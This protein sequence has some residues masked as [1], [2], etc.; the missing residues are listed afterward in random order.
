MNAVLD[1]LARLGVVPVLVL[2]DAS[3][4]DALAAALIEGGL[5]TAEVTLRTPAALDAIGR[6]ASHSDL[7]VG[8]GTVTSPY[9]VGAAV[10]AGAT[11]IVSPG[12][13]TAVSKECAALG[14]PL[15]PGV[16]TPTEVQAALDAGWEVLKFFPA[17]AS[18]GSAMVAALSAPFPAARFVP[19][20]GIRPDALSSY[21]TLGSVHAVGGTWIAPA[22]DV[23]AG[24]FSEIALRAAAA[25]ATVKVFR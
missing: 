25:A 10:E 22:A 23:N 9:Q 1:R 11:Y 24:R 12:F 14:V 20:G 7:L 15:I 3:S 13:S 8:A 21:L 16:V 17:E 5:P 2:D 6:L 18:G 4:A 19:T